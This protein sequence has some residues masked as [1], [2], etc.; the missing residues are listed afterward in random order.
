MVEWLIDIGTFNLKL[1]CVTFWALICV[2]AIL[3]NV[4]KAISELKE[5]N[6]SYFSKN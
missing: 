3:K 2:A 4:N 6:K 1:F 5:K